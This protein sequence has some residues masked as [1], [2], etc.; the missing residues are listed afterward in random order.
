[1]STSPSLVA[2]PPGV[3]R[4]VWR[5]LL[6]P[7]LL[8][9]ALASLWALATPI[10]GSPDEPAHVVK[11]A[12]VVRGEL[13]PSEMIAAGGV[14]EVPAAFDYEYSQG[15]FAFFSDVPAS[16]APPLTADPAAPVSSHSSASLYNPVYYALVGWPSLLMPD[17]SGIYAMRI[18]S[19]VLC[20]FFIAA[21]FWMIASWRSRRLP[22][23][24]VLIGLTPIVL[25]LMGTVNPNALEFTGGLALF[26][27]ML[28]IVLEPDE[29]RL[30]SRL[31]LVVVAAALVSNTRGISPLWVAL[32]LVLPLILLPGRRLLRLLTRPSVLVSILLIIATAL[33]SAWWT[34]SS[35]SLGTSP[36]AGPEI[37]PEVPGVGLG[38]VDAFFGEFG[39]F[40]LRMRQ[41]VGV[42]G[43]LDTPLSPTAYYLVYLLVAALV[44]GVVVFVRGRKLV[45]VIATALVFVAVPPAVQSVYVAKGGYIWQGRY[46]LILL[47]T[48]LLAM[49]ACI[50]ASARFDAWSARHRGLATAASWLV[51]LVWAFVTVWAF[52]T[53]LRRMSVGYRNDWLQMLDPGAWV[54]PLG[55]VPLVVLFGLSALGLAALVATT[56]R[57]VRPPDP[58]PAAPVERQG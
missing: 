35:N 49:G 24:A 14:L 17:V 7:W 52:L 22:A 58:V 3:R 42:L 41:M 6:L 50:A 15:C 12:S 8:L 23:A 30:G 25:Y 21:C 5:S 33:F 56:P 47:M 36:S 26:T 2:S 51:A 4:S 31:V 16:C 38:P 54:P 37:V 48:L 20:S 29:R 28:G 40:Y 10:A 44:L 55:I 39:N 46:S 1:M 27:A 13:L 9:A 11:A 43:W 57:D 18:V 45:F 34:L 53:T 19:A 32:L